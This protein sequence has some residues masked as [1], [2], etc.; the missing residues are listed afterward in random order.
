MLSGPR[1]GFDLD[2]EDSVRDERG[3]G[4]GWKR[5][6]RWWKMKMPLAVY[7]AS[8]ETTKWGVSEIE[9]SK[10]SR[11]LTEPRGW[12]RPVLFTSRKNNLLPETPVSNFHT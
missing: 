3:K 8:A 9:K 5:K 2:I 10:T 12:N 1:T 11:V 4:N 6:I 7:N